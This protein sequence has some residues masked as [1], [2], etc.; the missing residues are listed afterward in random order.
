MFTAHASRRIAAAV[1]GAGAVLVTGAATASAAPGCTAGD[2][3]AVESQ[4]AAAMT[5]YFF[6]HPA[7]NDFFTSVQG[8]PKSQAFSQTQAYLAANPQT[9]AEINAIRGPVFDLRARCNIP[10]NSLIRGVL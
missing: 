9:Q 10:T 4:V 5:G 8:L 7:V 1:L 6:T 2:I 3:T